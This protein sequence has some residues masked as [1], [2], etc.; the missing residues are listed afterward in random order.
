MVFY[1]WVY[2]LYPVTCESMTLGV[3]Y[4]FDSVDCVYVSSG[5]DVLEDL[6]SANE[7]EFVMTFFDSYMVINPA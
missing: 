3:T 7:T 6:R 2:G 5:S 4:D 1:D